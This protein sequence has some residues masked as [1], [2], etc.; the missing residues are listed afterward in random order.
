MLL[1]RKPNRRQKLRGNLT[2]VSKMTSW[3]HPPLLIP[4]LLIPLL[5]I[6]LLLIPLHLSLI[7]TLLHPLI[8]LL[9]I[10]LAESFKRDRLI[11]FFHGLI[12]H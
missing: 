3:L 4:P 8:L 10:P 7:Q 6:P 12:S 11:R 2:S 5:L 9:L 1:Q